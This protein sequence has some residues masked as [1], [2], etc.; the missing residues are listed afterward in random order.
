VKYALVTGSTKGIGYAITKK[1]M[2]SGYFVYMN[3]ANDDTTANAIDLPKDM[4]RIIRA[5]LS[6]ENGAEILTS[7][8]KDEKNNLDCIVLNAGA[9]C[10][11]TFNDVTYADWSTVMNANVTIPF[12]L[13][14]EL[15]PL[16]NEHGSIIFIGSDLGIYPHAISTVYSV[17]KAA[18]HMLARS[19]VK[20]FANRNIR[21]NAIAPGFIETDWQKDRPEWLR[22]KIENKIAQK[23]FGTPE[24]VAD[25]CMCLIGSTYIN[26]AII[27]VDGG[28]CFE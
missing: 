8:I 10:R 17:S 23:R 18:T 20:E 25:A 24:E 7:S 13:C 19:L 9:T 3:Y 22:E 21:G 15:S 28:Y 16:T 6:T 27:Q 1:L 2:K 26:G 11:K 5:D 4:H 12:F 14:K